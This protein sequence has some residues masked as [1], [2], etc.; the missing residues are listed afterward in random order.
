MGWV[1][2]RQLNLAKLNALDRRMQGFDITLLGMEFEEQL[3][4]GYIE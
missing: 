2:Y 4:S 3:H 1:R